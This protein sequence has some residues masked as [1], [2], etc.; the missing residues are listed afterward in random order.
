MGGGGVDRPDLL[1]HVRVY[2][3]TNISVFIDQRMSI[4]DCMDGVVFRE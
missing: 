3:F 1:V 4:I 2:T